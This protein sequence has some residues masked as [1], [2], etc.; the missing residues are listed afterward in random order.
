MLGNRKLLRTSVVALSTMSLGAMTLLGLGAPQV[1]AASS[2]VTV[3]YD[4]GYLDSLDPVNWDA[5]ILVDQGTILEGLYGYNNKNQIVP[6]IAQQ[7]VP[8]EGG[9]VWTI[10]LRHNAKW[11]NGQPVT[12]QDF[13]YSWMRLLSPSDSAGA[14]WSGVA[15]ILLNGYAYHAG[16]V[17]ASDVGVKVVNPYELKLTLTGATNVTGWLALS[18]S[19]PLYPPSVEKHPSDWF[20]PQYFVGDG[21]YVVHSYVPNGKLVLTRNPDYV[22]RS[23]EFNVGNV[24]QINLIPGPA[25]PVEDYESGILTATPIYSASDYKFAEE[26]FPSQVHRAAE[27]DINYLGWDHSVDPS[28][29]RNQL[30]REAIAMAVNRGPIVNPVLNN[31]VGATSV[32]GYPG[33][34]TYKYEHNPYSYNVAKARALLAK[35]GYPNGKGIGTLYLYTQTV[36]NSAQSV[37]MGEALAQEFKS[38]L[39]LNFK[40]EPTNAT[41]YGEMSYG[42]IEPGVLPGYTIDTGLTNWNQTE[43]WP[44]GADQWVTIDNSGTVGPTAFAQ[45]AEN[46]AF[47]SYNPLEVKA[48]GNPNDTSLGVSYASWKPLITAAQQALAYLKA[49][50]AKQPPAY[51]AALTV[52]GTPSGATELADFENSWKTATTAAAKHAAW[53]DMWKWVGSYSNG[54]EYGSTIGLQDQVYI[55]Q[56]EPQLEYHMRMWEAELGNTGSA[57][58]AAHL[59]ADMGNAMI[60]SGYVVPL[61]YAE[62]IYAAKPDLTGVQ[63]N[64]YTWGYFYQLQYLNLK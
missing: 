59:A 49:W 62:T 51:R 12:A 4:F 46:W 16:A 41:L 38:E 58:T 56:H 2:V 36:S 27:A 28:P 29:L 37:A 19:M 9:R 34:P 7:S 53:V 39:N 14:I 5:E 26:H 44:L 23:G 63:P 6:K 32:F 52:P 15:S 13:Y 22:G 31:M 1:S 21:P 48:W 45:Y 10:Y 8:S 20:D 60:Q 50:T 33:F 47:D 55:D 57:T 24:Q 42:G 25:V 64:P 3:P 40:I 17:P 11:S 18:A 30:V 43:Q 54:G 35:A 61:N